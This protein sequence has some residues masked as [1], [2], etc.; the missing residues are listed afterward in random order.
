VYPPVYQVIKMK[1]KVNKTNQILVAINHHET[2]FLPEQFK[3]SL[4]TSAK[5]GHSRVIPQ[6]DNR[7][8]ILFLIGNYLCVVNLP[9]VHLR[10]KQTASAIDQKDHYT[11]TNIFDSS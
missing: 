10:N 6:L 4:I 2:R 3:K 5:N 7:F 11:F 1:I 8:Q 9:D